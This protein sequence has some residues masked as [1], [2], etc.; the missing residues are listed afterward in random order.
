MA[1]KEVLLPAMGEGIT[2]AT[3]IRW[4]VKEGDLVKIDQPLV[5]IATDKVDSE[6]PAAFEG[7]MKKIIALAGV[8]PKIGETIAIIEVFI[9]GENNNDNDDVLALVEDSGFSEKKPIFLSKI[10]SN[11]NRISNPIDESADYSELPFTPPYIRLLASKLNIDLFELARFAELGKNDSFRKHHVEMY[12]ESKDYSLEPSID[13]NQKSGNILL[14]ETNTKIKTEQWLE[15]ADVQEMSRMRKI[16]ADRMLASSKSIP[17]VTS[18]IEVDITNMVYWREHV[19]DIFLKKHNVKLT[20]TPLF[21]EAIVAALKQYPDVNVS[22]SGNSII[23]KKEINIGMAT[24]LPDRNLIVPVIKNADQ[25]GLHGLSQVVSEL[26]ERARANELKPTD[27][28]EGTFTFTNIG[29]F[30]SLTG[31]PLINMPESAILG[32]G[33]IIKKPFVV[34][35][36]QGNSIG[37]RDIVMLSLA[38]DHRVIDGSLGGLFLKHLSDNLGNF[39]MNRE[40]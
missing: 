25:L 38:Y 17:H 5:E 30:G 23:T 26:S 40:I 16:I 31:T 8:I 39:N 21:V 35:T 28:T 29:V 37:I 10:K 32:I 20:Y 3:I 34:K 7:K 9:E 11:K 2:E 19:K 14:K 18:F 4:L 12:I 13:S 6:V 22:I 36:E 24:V 15:N 1:F 33:A 27:I